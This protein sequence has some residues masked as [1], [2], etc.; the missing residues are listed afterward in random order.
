[1]HIVHAIIP[2]LIALCAKIEQQAFYQ[3]RHKVHTIQA[4]LVC[5]MTTDT[6][7]K[8]NKHHFPSIVSVLKP[9]IVAEYQSHN[10]KNKQT[11]NLFWTKIL[12]IVL[13][14]P[15]FIKPWQNQE[16]AQEL[17][18]LTKVSTT[19]S[20]WKKTLQNNC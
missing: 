12:H 10:T 7:S 17:H 13:V 5:C 11:N 8:W 15:L 2:L 9:T 20:F 18:S 14:S 1:M 16:C 19:I 3:Q 6:Q 4:R